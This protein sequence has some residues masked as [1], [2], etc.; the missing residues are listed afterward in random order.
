MKLAEHSNVRWRDRGH[1]FAVAARAMR[2]V[3]VDYARQ[4]K[5]LKRGGGVPH[6]AVTEADLAVEMQ[7][8]TLIALD[9][10]L[11]NLAAMDPRLIR[12]VECRFFAGYS[13][14]ETADALSI[15]LRTVQRDWKRARAWLKVE[16]SPDCSPSP[17]A[18]RR[19]AAIST[20]NSRR[21]VNAPQR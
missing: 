2:Q 8:E 21:V 1:F 13:E 16:M 6:V 17:R 12:I 20:S 19:D 14:R 15:S 7:A 5:A 3:I 9:R 10:A 11:T 18:G 4:R